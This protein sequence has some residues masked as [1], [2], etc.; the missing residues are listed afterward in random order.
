M[1]LT[2]KE[3]RFCISPVIV[4][5][6]T[7]KGFICENLAVHEDFLL[8]YSDDTLNILSKFN[9]PVAIRNALTMIAEGLSIPLERAEAI[10]D[11]FIQ[12]GLLIDEASARNLLSV[13]QTWWN[14]GWESAWYLHY[15]TKDYKFLDYS[16]PHAVKTDRE[17]MDKYAAVDRMPAIYKDYSDAKQV[18]LP[19]Y[20]LALVQESTLD[21]LALEQLAHS[22]SSIDAVVLSTLLYLIGGKIGDK[23]W[24]GQDTLIRRTSPSGGARHPT[25]LY[26]AI[27]DIPELQT[28]LYHY[29]VHHHGLDPIRLISAPD[30]LRDL[31]AAAPDIASRVR[32]QPRVV[33]FLTS[34]FERSM[35]R[36]RDSRSY[37][38]ICIDIGHIVFTFRCVARSLG[39]KSFVGQGINHHRAESMLGLDPELEGTMFLCAIEGK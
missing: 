22:T 10:V 1:K 20:N 37:R 14:Y 25:E 9:K 6:P 13:R 7:A 15:A 2:D 35:W 24:P 36:Y 8:H 23:P 29:N 3:K 11:G 19:P 30:L 26:V 34:V 39:M 5:N 16:Q 4:L 31:T 18:P 17:I 12:A 21:L 28:G 38:V 27:L 33:I 32:F